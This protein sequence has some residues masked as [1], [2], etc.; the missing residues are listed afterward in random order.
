[1]PIEIERG[2]VME[3]TR[4]K[5]SA[6]KKP[7]AAAKKRGTSP[8]KT[9]RKTKPKQPSLVKE[10]IALIK[11]RVIALLVGG[12][13]F[14]LAAAAGLFY[15][16]QTYSP[17]AGPLQQEFNSAAHMQMNERLAYW[18]DYLSVESQGQS[19]LSQIGQAPAISDSAPL[20]PQKFDC[21]T[22]VETVAALSRSKYYGDFYRNLIA[23]RYKDGKAAFENRNHFP[24]ADWVPNNESAGILKDITFEIAKAA[25]VKARVETKIID[26]GQWL[27]KQVGGGKVSRTIASAVESEW[28]KPVEA[29]VSYIP[30]EDLGRVIDKIPNGTVVNLV[31]KSDDRFPVLITHQGFIVREKGAVFFRHASVGGHVAKV[32]FRDYFQKQRKLQAKWPIVG[33]NLNAIQ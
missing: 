3:K 5:S 25:G 15:Y 6:G 33:F 31:R 16:F 27:A 12:S 30:A 1:M 32:G 24:E 11:S 7:K 26:R 19:K 14:A 13:A 20:I 23:I 17:K 10:I 9:S 21:T 4:R 22:Y 18:A 28:S 2:T 8:R 29:K